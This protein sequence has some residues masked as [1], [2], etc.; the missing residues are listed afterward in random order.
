MSRKAELIANLELV[1]SEIPDGVT[2]IVVTKTYPVSD[3]EILYEAGVRDFGENRDQEGAQKAPQLP[4]D[5]NWHFQ[6]Q[7]QSNK[8]SSIAS[9]ADYIHSLDKLDHA[10][11]LNKF[12]TAPKPVFI[13]V[14]LDGQ[15]HRGGI[16]AD[17]IP[18]L[19]DEIEK[20]KMISPIGL[21]AVAPLDEDADSAYA[22]LAQIKADIAREFSYIKYLSAGMS[23]DYKLAISHG[24][25]HVRIGSS[26]LGSR[27]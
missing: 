21:M 19:L 25:T 20:L 13:Q 2:L 1:K 11:K 27:G 22:K 8:L 26:I 12:L 16:A 10:K 9:W 18:N 4:S 3:V 17:Q 23:G 24:A 5:A 7:I 15:V 14:S 6:G